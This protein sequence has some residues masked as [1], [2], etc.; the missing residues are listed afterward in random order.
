MCNPS[1]SIENRICTSKIEECPI[2]AIRFFN[3]V[4][5]P[6][7]DFESLKIK[8]N[9]YLHYSKTQDALPLNKIM[10]SEG[11]PCMNVDQTNTRNGRSYHFLEAIP[12]GCFK[13]N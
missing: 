7:H 13:D 12:S 2:N 1:A 4:I 6:S 5:I 9:L 3:T 10:L 8:E 11:A